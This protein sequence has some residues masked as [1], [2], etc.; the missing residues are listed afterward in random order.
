[1]NAGLIVAALLLVFIAVY[2][3]R[4]FKKTT[5]HGK[6]QHDQ[7]DRQQLA[8]QLFDGTPSVTYVNPTGYAGVSTEELVSLASDRGYRLVTEIGQHAKRRVVFELRAA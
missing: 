3:T 6:A 5:E 8:E 2:M 7:I 1:M 4:W